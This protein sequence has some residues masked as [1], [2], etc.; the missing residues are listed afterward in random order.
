MSTASLAFSGKGPVASETVERVLAAARR[1]GYAGPDP[2][3]AS[4]RQGRSGVVGVVVEGRL[5]HAFRDPFAVSVLDG[6]SQVLDEVPAGMLLIAQPAGQPERVIGQLSSTGLDA[7]VFCLCGPASNPAVEHLATR[8]IPMLGDGTPADP[9][10]VQLVL[11]NRAASATI[12]RYLW[13]LG[14]RRVGHLLMPLA[15]DGVTALVRPTQLDRAVFLDSRDRALGFLDVFGADQPMAQTSLPDV[16]QGAKAA[17]LL[18]DRPDRERP[19]AIVAQSDLLAVGAV[20]TAQDMGLRVPE[21]LSVTGF[22]GVELPWFPGTLTTM[23]QHGEAKGR[24]LGE[25]LGELL[26]GRRPADELQASELRI[27]TTTAPLG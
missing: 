19:T 22:D 13:D 8:G 10:V 14:H 11:D 4:L 20:R 25:L 9:R 12:S 21:D 23:D 16:E 24:R 17:R 2:L 18:L 26:E 3:A 1:L 15:A 6:L 27:G 5:L 7:V